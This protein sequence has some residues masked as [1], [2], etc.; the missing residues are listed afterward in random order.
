[1]GGGCVPAWWRAARTEPKSAGRARR[2][3][4]E[5]PGRNSPSRLSGQPCV[6]EPPGLPQGLLDFG[7]GAKLHHPEEEP[8][9]IDLQI[10]QAA[11][12]SPSLDLGRPVHLGSALLG[13]SPS[14]LAGVSGF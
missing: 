10:G 1:L 4:I 5:N 12:P 8:V 7:E 11:D 3:W 14:P 6:K 9:Q 2:S 13:R